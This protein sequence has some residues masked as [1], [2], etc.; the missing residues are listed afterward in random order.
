MTSLAPLVAE[1][2]ILTGEAVALDLQPVGAGLRIAGGAIDFV[3]S[4]LFYLGALWLGSV[5]VNAG[6]LTASTMQIYA[7]CALV[8]AFVALPTAVETATRGR[9]LGKLAVGGRIVRADGGAIGFR[10]AFI[11]ALVGVLE[12]VMT[13]GGIAA[14]TTM[15][16]PRAQRLGDLV[17]GTYSARTRTPALPQDPP[18]LPPQMA[19][20][21]EVAD[22]ARM[23]VR[24]DHRVSQFVANM[25]NMSPIARSRLSSEL[26]REVAP[27]VSP[28]PDV[29]PEALL[30]S[31]VA[32]RRGRDLRAL[33]SRDEIA[34]RL[35]GRA[36]QR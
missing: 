27:F 2:E 14:V 35:S 5:L 21:A 16:T 17:A 28:L 33:R 34:A 31:V 25:A 7:I 6:A 15:F 8:T 36:A 18:P 32:V 23:P 26:A 30:A 9:S 10:H 22:V 12:V 11:R 4:I 1:D 29:P 24:L 19:G 3:V 13:I 20:W